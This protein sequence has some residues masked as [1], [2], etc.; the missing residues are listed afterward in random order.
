[1]SIKATYLGNKLKSYIS[2]RHLKTN[3]SKTKLLTSTLYTCPILILISQLFRRNLTIIHNSSL[4]P[5]S[6]LSANTLT[7]ISSKYIQKPSIS[8]HLYFSP[9]LHYL[10]SRLFPLH[11]SFGFNSCLPNCL[12]SKCQSQ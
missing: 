9:G 8:Y 12:F 2:N 6:N 1:M 11:R 7:N 3:I 5:I 4:T 10:L